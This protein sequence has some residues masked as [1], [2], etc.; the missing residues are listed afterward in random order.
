MHQC[1]LTEKKKPQL[2][3]AVDKLA[4]RAQLQIQNETGWDRLKSIFETDEFNGVSPELDNAMSAGTLGLF[5]GMFIG[6]IPASKMAYDDFIDRNKAASFENHFDAKNKL[7]FSV[8]KAMAEG[9]WRVGWRL[10]LFTGAFTLFTTAVSTY[11]NK[12]SVFEYS[13]GGLLAGSMYKITMGPKAM[14]SGG[15]AGAAIGS[16]A[17]VFTVGLMKISG[18]TT[19]D[20]RYWK[21]GWKE[22]ANRCKF[23]HNAFVLLIQQ[24]MLTFTG[25]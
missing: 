15:I 25:K 21:K 13:A 22:A 6:G 1:E 20:L 8:T 11:R 4:E 5:A 2:K 24:K 14:V 10:A 12:S 23:I 7:Q 16:V 19:E 3:C 17:G 18:T 9:G